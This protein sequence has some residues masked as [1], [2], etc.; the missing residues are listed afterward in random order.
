MLKSISTFLL[1]FCKSNEVDELFSSGSG[2]EEK[3]FNEE[4]L[5]N[6]L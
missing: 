1:F 2:W 4:V 3:Y 6:E 5:K